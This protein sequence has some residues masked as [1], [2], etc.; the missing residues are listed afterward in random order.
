M[1][2]LG[3]NSPSFEILFALLVSQNSIIRGKINPEGQGAV[4][5]KVIQR[6]ENC[7]KYLK[8]NGKGSLLD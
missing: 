4:F 6:D 8:T 2:N 3:V 5:R 7:K 1:V